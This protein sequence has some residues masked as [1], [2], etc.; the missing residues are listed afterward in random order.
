MKGPVK[1]LL[2]RH[3]RK[4]AA[5]A[6]AAS[7][8]AS[9]PASLPAS[10]TAVL[11]ALAAALA[12]AL[13]QRCLPAAAPAG[14]SGP[15]EQA[16]AAAAN[17]MVGGT[18]V[19][20]ADR[21]V[22]QRDPATRSA[23]VEV[24][25]MDCRVPEGAKLQ[26]KAVAFLDGE[27]SAAQSAED[28][29]GWADAAPQ[30]E[31][32]RYA[33]TLAVPQGGWYRL[34]ARVAG[35][36]G[37]P[38]AEMEGAARWGVGM[39]ILCIGQSNML[40]VGEPATPEAFAVADDRVSNFMN[41]TWTHLSDP[42]TAGDESVSATE[43][44]GGGSMAPT[45]G[46]E[47]VAAYDMPVGVIPAAHGGSSMAD[48]IVRDSSNPA[49]RSHLY[50]NS[51]Y[52]ARAAGGVEFILMNQGEY[53]VAL[54]V[55]PAQYAAGMH[56]LRANYKADGVGAPIIL[57]QLGNQRQLEDDEAMA[58][59]RAAQRAL[60]DGGE[61]FL[62]GVV[63]MGLTLNSDGI[64]WDTESQKAI[65]ARFANAI[66][67]ILGDSGYYMGPDVAG[68][69]FEDGARDAIVVTIEH[70]GGTDF[71]PAESVTGF[72]AEADGRK[73][74]IASAARVDATHIRLTLAEAAPDGAAARVRYL[75]GV[76]PDV[77]GMVVDNSALALPLNAIG[78]IGVGDRFHVPGK[79]RTGRLS[80][81]PRR[82]SAFALARAF[83]SLKGPG[84]RGAGTVWELPYKK[85]ALK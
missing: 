6:S 51:L 14:L 78:W 84:R 32:G 20:F 5:Q 54:G 69:A 48:W 76:T 83:P 7:P 15:A 39:N 37:E 35:G 33:A 85:G 3:R 60:D 22:I 44:I 29:T 34:V 73:L 68:A 61:N 38:L 80:R 9:S 43:T 17:D 10:A 8:P 50:G 2:I 53:E 28:A 67:Y 63:E 46:N 79:L 81:R 62:L 4:T 82:P 57:C 47:L 70:A 41:E 18:L 11:A 64:H 21:Q 27:A 16:Q 77:S 58:G 23:T 72:E 71:S 52:R 24:A 31:D 36:D 56:L 65:G 55:D 13:A 42:Y 1:T 66:R 26:F 30:G 25:A 75:H 74:A 59:I 45:L 19:D 49:D 12:F 40:A